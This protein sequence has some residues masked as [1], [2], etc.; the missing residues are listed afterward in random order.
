MFSFHLTVLIGLC[1]RKI[2]Y[3]ETANK[4][5]R[6]LKR[7]TE[8]VS[9]GVPFSTEMTIFCFIGEKPQR[10]RKA[11]SKQPI[12]TTKKLII[13]QCG[14][15]TVHNFAS[16]QVPLNPSRIIYYFARNIQLLY[17]WILTKNF[18]IISLAKR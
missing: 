14:N 16:E 8:K 13:A 7:S 9:P 6:S 5:N 10:T 12:H 1:N 18:P 4:N 3:Q 15:S 11:T 2:H 17:P